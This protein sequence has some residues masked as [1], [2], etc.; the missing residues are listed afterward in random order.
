MQLNVAARNLLTSQPP[1][2]AAL[3]QIRFALAQTYLSMYP[4]RR[5]SRSFRREDSGMDMSDVLDKASKLLIQLRE[6]KPENP[7]YRFAL[8]DAWSRRSRF[9]EDDAAAV[10]AHEESLAILEELVEDFPD[11][12]RYRFEL[13][14]RLS[15]SYRLKKCRNTT[16]RL[17]RAVSLAE[18]LAEQFPTV[19]EYQRLWAV[20][21]TRDGFHHGRQND[22]DMAVTQ[23]QAAI[24]VQEKITEQQPSETYRSSR[25]FWMR[26]GLAEALREQG[27]LDQSREL[28]ERSIDE[29]DALVQSIQEREGR[30]GFQPF[31]YIFLQLYAQLAATLEK[32]GD[33]A[34][35]EH[36]QTKSKELEELRTKWW[37]NRNSRSE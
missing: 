17:D 6:E 21:L 12:P 3:P 34:A 35:A 8:A 36:W 19:A 24:A 28:L 32:Q 27:E 31:S 29:L 9:Q 2:V 1:E 26:L 33:H 7:A 15:V 18:E 16:K 5:G 22:W 23:Y 20:C 13:A 37:E 4:R 14:G 11:R 25:R 30:N 10:S